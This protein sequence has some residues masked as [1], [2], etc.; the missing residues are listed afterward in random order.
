MTQNDGLVAARA[1]ARNLNILLKYIRLY[2]T[3]HQRT[4]AQLALTWQELSAAANKESGLLLGVAEDVLLID[5]IAVDGLGER[6]F[7][8]ILKG[9]GISSMHFAP[10][11]DRAEFDRIVFAFAAGK[12]NEVGKQLREAAGSSIKINELKFVAQDESQSRATE[13]V[14]RALGDSA[15]EMKEWLS[16]PEKLVQLIAAAEGKRSQYSGSGTTMPGQQLGA[17]QQAGS[18]G[19]YLDEPEMQKVLRILARFGELESGDSAGR[20][21]AEQLASENPDACALL[22]RAI[23]SLPAILNEPIGGSVA[24]LAEKLA[25]RFARQQFERGEV[26][27][28]AVHNLM[29]RMAKE[30]DS[31]KKVLSSH[32]Y[33]MQKAGM[34]VESHAGILDRQFW[35]AMPEAGKKSVLLSPDAWC[36]PPR[37]I[38]SYVVELTGRGDYELANRILCNYVRQLA[39]PDEEAR[40]KT[41]NGTSE[42]ADLFGA[43]GGDL[44][45]GALQ[46][47]GLRLQVEP[48]L[49]HQT[50]LAAAYVRL[51][52]EASQRSDFAALRQSLNILERLQEWRPR[53]AMEVRPRITVENRIGEFIAE[54]V[55]RH[56]FPPSLLGLLRQV[57]IPTAEHIS[58]RVIRCD[59]RAEIDCYVEL[60]ETIGPSI[61]EC[62]V[63][64][65][66]AGNPQEF[67]RSIGIASRLRPQVVEQELRR[68]M[69]TFSRSQQDAVVR[70]LGAAGAPERG[71]LLAGVLDALDALVVPEALDEIGLTGGKI[72]PAPLLEM[73]AGEGL[74]TGKEYIRVKAMEALGRLREPSATELLSRFCDGRGLFQ[75]TRS[76]ELRVVAAQALALID[77]DRV[78]WLLNHGFTVPELRVG[79]LPWMETEWSRARRYPRINPEKSISLLALTD[80]GKY[81]VGVANINLGGGLLESDRRLPRRGDAVL[82][83]QSGL[84]RARSHVVLREIA[85]GNMAFEVVNINLESRGKWRKMLVDYSPDFGSNASM[86]L[87]FLTGNPSTAERTS[88]M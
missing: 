53:T 79:A 45:T 84:S 57:P 33:K 82:E 74:A 12:P 85:A 26:K 77:P 70:Q 17:Q 67:S 19:P 54:A 47:T 24:S 65:L 49:E 38:R 40:K 18:G 37:N 59:R 15:G 10:G 42:L 29:E 36:I 25:I 9:A 1:F 81:R 72:S 80:K 50:L 51:T 5:G 76:R 46:T 66:R 41:A 87:P 61:A 52:Q 23:R 22:R 2:G 34:T 4:L 58:A 6:S 63:G 75:L 48:T 44:L 3:Q 11:M 60:A 86:A 31:L 39:N 68:R 30:I 21:A 35:A 20:L 32:E 64:M 62:M 8:A 28:D 78:P 27:V 16:D 13:L 43:A 56:E 69:L 55:R 7:A 73:A 88:A 14:A 71:E 83:W